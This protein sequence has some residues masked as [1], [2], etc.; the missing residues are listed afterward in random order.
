M[1]NFKEKYL[2][3]IVC[4]IVGMPVNSTHIGS[5]KPNP[6]H[7]IGEVEDFFPTEITLSNIRCIVK[8]H[9][10]ILEIQDLSRYSELF[11]GHNQIFPN[12][13][14]F[15]RFAPSKNIKFMYLKSIYYKVYLYENGNEDY[16]FEI[17]KE[18]LN[19]K[20]NVE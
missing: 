13:S 2:K 5:P 14:Y 18:N 20:Q 1:E 10:N 4:L 11:H 3:D 8:L 12:T 17:I 15:S 7:I 9:P 16:F 19:N 6:V